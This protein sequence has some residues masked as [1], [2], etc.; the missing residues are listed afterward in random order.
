MLA[1][2]NWEGRDAP[3][4]LAQTWNDALRLRDEGLPIR[5]HIWYGFVDHVDWDTALRENNNRPNACALVDLD[6]RPHPVGE[7][8]RALATAALRGEFSP[9]EMAD[10][11]HGADVYESGT[12]EFVDDLAG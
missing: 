1:E 7:Q 6:R 2:T 12:P 10:A 5:G 9:V 8:Y 3:A 11:A 4:W